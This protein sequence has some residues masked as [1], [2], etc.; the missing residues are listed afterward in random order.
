M[1]NSM[2]LKFVRFVWQN[3]SINT[4]EGKKDALILSEYY[5]L[6]IKNGFGFHIMSITK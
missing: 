6:Q 2:N 1:N 5:S 4:N 3:T